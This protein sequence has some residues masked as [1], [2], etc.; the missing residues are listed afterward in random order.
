MSWESMFGLYS[1]YRNVAHL[2]QLWAINWR[3]ECV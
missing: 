2:N 3:S 1:V